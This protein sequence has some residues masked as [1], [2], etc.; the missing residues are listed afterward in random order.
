M[1]R[2]WAGYVAA[3]CVGLLFVGTLFP[4]TAIVPIDPMVVVRTGDRAQG[5]VAQRYFLAAGWGWP[6]LVAPA[7]DGVNIGLADSLPLVMLLLKPVRAWLPPGFFVQES[8]IALVWVLQP[9]AAVYALRGAGVRSWPG[10]LAVAALSFLPTLMARFGHTALCT[11]ALIL[12][13][14]GVYLRTVRGDAVWW[15][16]TVLLPASM[17]VHPYLAA[18]VAAV[19]LAG[20]VGLLAGGRRWVRAAGGV[21]IG[22]AAAAGA[23][24]ALG[25]GG[26]AVA[27]GYGVFSMNLLAPWVPNRSSLFGSLAI[28]ATGGQAGE[29]FQY[30][31][32]G[33]LGLLL[34]AFGLIAAGRVRVPWRRHGGLM[35]VLLGLMLFAVSGQAYV[36]RVRILDVGAVPDFVQQFRVTGRFFWPVAYALLIGAVV[37]VVRGLPRGVSILVL[38]AAVGVQAADLGWSRDAIQVW[39]RPEA[40]EIDAPALGPVVARHGRLT[41]WP[42]SF[43]GVDGGQSNFMQLLLLASRT[44]PVVNTM[45]TARVPAG[46]V[47]DAPA[48]LGAAWRPGELRVV[49]PQAPSTDWRLV[50]G[51]ERLCRRS[52]TLVVCSEDEGAILALPDRVE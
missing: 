5:M 40:W 44:T 38:A 51:A 43:C 11:H 22:L 52:G 41:L 7:L 8:W 49:L 34:V 19:L 20:P 45:Y 24:V 50:P 1:I 46:L 28:D 9:V 42:A 29:G 18:M 4:W 25:F 10:M 47:C 23:A 36:G 12:M 17:L 15:V 2:R 6:P 26:A 48:T 39:I 32:A 33:V 31:G 30:L 37:V 16:P 14:I 13:S 35:L 27:L 21:L 3:L